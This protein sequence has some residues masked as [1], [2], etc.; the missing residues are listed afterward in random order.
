MNHAMASTD[1]TAEVASSSA[2]VSVIII[3]FNT[4]DLTRECLNSLLEQTETM[5]AQIIVVDNH[6]SDGSAEM[7]AHE[8]PQVELVCSHVNLGFGNANNLGLQRAHGRYLVLLNSDAFLA[9]G[10]LKL[11]LQHMNETPNCGLGGGR[12][13]G[14]DGSWQPSARMFHTL[15]ADAMVYTGL[16]HRFPHSRVFA[17][18]DRTWAD[19]MQSASVDWVPGAF[20][21]IRPEILQKIGGCFDPAFF[22]Y[23]EEV[24]LCKRIKNAGYE[25]WY[26]PDVVITHIGGESSRRL[27]NLEFSS[28]AAQVVLWRMRSTLLYYRKHGGWRVH[29]ARWMERFYY[30]G[31]SLRNRLSGSAWRKERAAYYQSMARLMQQAWRDTRGGRVSPPIPW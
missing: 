2:D 20:S 28:T 6:S 3:S 29:M 11:S 27:A 31:S 24:D 18:L 16:S 8:F 9:P 30:L 12:L 1:P 22:L 5:H 7:I 25:V 19:Q 13:V 26:W 10:A 4:R 21:V 15:F 17:G 23:Y 14:R